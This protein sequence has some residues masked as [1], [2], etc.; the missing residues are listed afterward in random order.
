[1]VGGITGTE[2][3]RARRRTKLINIAR[4]GRGTGAEEA[5]CNRPIELCSKYLSTISKFF[6]SYRN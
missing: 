1:M 4:K 6:S 3:L 2:F 5:E